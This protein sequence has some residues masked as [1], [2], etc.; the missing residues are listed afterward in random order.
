MKLLFARIK[1]ILH[2]LRYTHTDVHYKVNDKIIK[3]ECKE[4]KKVFYDNF[5]SKEDKEYF[6]NEVKN[7]FHEK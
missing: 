4:C 2:C 6:E 5:K 7:K 3:I 1:T